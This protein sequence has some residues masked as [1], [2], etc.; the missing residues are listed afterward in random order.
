MRRDAVKVGSTTATVAVILAIGLW[1]LPV[2]Y[3]ADNELANKVCATCHGPAGQSVAPTFPRLAGQTAEYLDTQI[4]AFRD[5][6]RADPHARA[7]MWGMAAQ[8]SDET[9]AG[10]AAYYSALPPAAGI[11]ADPGEVAKGRSIFMDGIEAEQ[12]PACHACHGEK[13]E[14]I[15]AVPRLAGQ[16]RRYLER[17]LEA[18]AS[19]LRAN[20]IMHDN[21]KNLTAAEISAVAAFLSSQ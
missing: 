20:E 3:A 15:G 14:G 8:L 2:A 21:S 12:V 13:A 7:Y 16:H 11:A 9:I 5:R 17:Q 10:L 6:T 19:N 1:S 18:F 4:K